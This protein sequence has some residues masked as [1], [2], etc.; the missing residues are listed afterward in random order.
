LVFPFFEK[1]LVKKHQHR[2]K[3]CACDGAPESIEKPAPKINTVLFFV[4][5]YGR[6]DIYCRKRLGIAEGRDFL[7]FSLVKVE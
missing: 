7:H 5:I 6:F 3:I 2:R 4:A 1:M